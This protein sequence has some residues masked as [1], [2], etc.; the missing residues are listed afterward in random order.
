MEK[1]SS[2]VRYWLM[3]SEPE[4]LSID[5]LARRPKKT[6]GWDGV[7]NYQARNFIKE[8]AAGDRAFFY[9]SN[10]APPGVAGIMEIVSAP[11]P[12]PTQFDRKSDYFEKRATTAAPVWFQVD[13][14]FAQKLGRLISLDE[15]RRNPA[16][17][18]MSLF[19]RPRLSVHPVAA[20]EWAAIL[21]AV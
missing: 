10:A 21:A 17:K 9:H 19:T 16:L 15:L 7:R 6:T 5:S 4:V 20:E 18:R 12:D 3:K 1:R 13:V 11:Y 8:M 14:K 2:A